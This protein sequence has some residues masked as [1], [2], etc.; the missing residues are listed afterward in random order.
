MTGSL[1]LIRLK[2]NAA[3]L[4]HNYIQR[5][6]GADYIVDEDEDH[7]LVRVNALVLADGPDDD[8][9][10]IADNADVPAKEWRMAL[11]R[12]AWGAE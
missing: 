1:R 12:R 2:I 4:L 8:A 7:N 5:R 11:V 10:G 9:P 6:G 3:F